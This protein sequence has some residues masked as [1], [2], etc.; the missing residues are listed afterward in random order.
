[1]PVNPAKH[2]NANPVRTPAHASHANQ[3]NAKVVR[4]IVNVKHENIIII[5][6]VVIVVTEV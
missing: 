5:Y 3:I 2:P 1:M 6:V 4:K